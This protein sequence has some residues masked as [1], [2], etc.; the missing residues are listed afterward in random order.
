MTLVIG[1]MANAE[2]STDPTVPTTAHLF[3]CADTMATYATLSGVAIT[4]HQSQGKIYALPSNFYLAFCDDYYWSHLVAM[5][6]HGRLLN[7]V[8]FSSDGV[9]DL[10]KNEVRHSFAYAYSWYRD[11]VLRQNL[12][13]TIDEYLHDT[14]LA[15]DLRQQGKDLLFGIAQ[16]VPA[17]VVIIGQTHRGPI[18]LQANGREIRE[19]TEFLISGAAADSAL[20]WFRLRDQNSGM[21][22][23]RSFYHMMEAKRFAQTDPTVGRITQIVYMPPTGEPKIFQDDGVTTL[24]NWMERFGPMKTDELDKPDIF[25]IFQKEAARVAIKQ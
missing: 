9:K 17:E 23:P 1:L 11:E 16:D 6:I 4:S 14:N 19:T 25:Q 2:Q 24:K 13:I 8:D 18:L 20:S 15:P 3:L 10:V 7:N 22:A 21:S 12:G 5:E